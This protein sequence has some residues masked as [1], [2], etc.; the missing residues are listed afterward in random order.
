MRYLKS[1]FSVAGLLALSLLPALAAAAEPAR[2]PASEPLFRVEIVVFKQLGSASAEDWDAFTPPQVSPAEE[3]EAP[4]PTP[5][6]PER[7]TGGALGVSPLGANDFRLAGIASA[8]QRRGDYQMLA[9]VGWIQ[10]ATARGSNLFVNLNEFGLNSNLLYGTAMLE[11]GRYLYLQLD[12]GYTPEEVPTGLAGTNAERGRV[13]FFIRQ[14]RRVR[15][16]ERHYFDH[17]AFG[18]IA[19]VTP[20]D[21]SQQTEPAPEQSQ[22]MPQEQTETDAPQ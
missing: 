20:L 7:A 2:E 5:N 18:V 3:A 12:L 11:R 10:P 4:A 19:I 13:T 21:T 16:G 15:T 6:D 17:P 8:L 1:L 22:G 9:H 14:K